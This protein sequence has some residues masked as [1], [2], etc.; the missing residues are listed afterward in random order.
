M[1]DPKSY[2]PKIGIIGGMGPAATCLLFEKIIRMTQVERDQD[3]LHIIINNDPSIP[4]R[5]AAILGRGPSPVEAIIRSANTLVAAGADHLL[6]PCMTSHAYYAAIQEQVEVPIVNAIEL[7]RREI[8][9]ALGDTGRVGLLATD[10]SLKGG[11]YSALES[12]CEI[13]TPL[14]DGQTRLMDAIYGPCGIKTIGANATAVETILELI[15]SLHARGAGLV[16]AGCTEISVAM[17]G[18]TADVPVVDPLDLLA[19]TAIHIGTGGDWRDVPSPSALNG[20][21]GEVA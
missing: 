9:H 5:T 7:I 13:N 18:R 2:S 19:G 21:H 11:V 10:G 1:S 15:S 20:K 4:D 17:Q 12:S 14:G 3:H 16:I 6:M 8:V